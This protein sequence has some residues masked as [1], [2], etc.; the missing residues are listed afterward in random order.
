MRWRWDESTIVGGCRGED[1]RTC[2]GGED[3]S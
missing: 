2:G 3:K 1:E